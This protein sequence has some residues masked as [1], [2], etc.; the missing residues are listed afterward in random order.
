MQIAHL[1]KQQRR[2]M[3]KTQKEQT[4]RKGVLNME[5]TYTNQGGYRLPNLA[6]P[7]QPQVRLGK[8]ALLRRSYLKEH[9]RILF[10]NL[11]TSGKLT[12]HLM[13]IEKAAQNRMEQVVKAMAAQEGVTEELKAR[14]QMEWVRRMNAI[15]DS[16]E[17]VIL[18]ELI[19]N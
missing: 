13:E 15:R 11:L 4:S 16:A 7:E 14:D 1:Q 9:R 3:L 18:R 17:E 5:L 2:G 10:T 12:E 19:Y 8:Y 6:V